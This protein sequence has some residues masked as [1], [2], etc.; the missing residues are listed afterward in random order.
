MNYPESNKQVIARAKSVLN[1]FKVQYGGEYHFGEVVDQSVAHL[2]F[3]H[4]YIV[5]KFTDMMRG[6]CACHWLAI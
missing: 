5:E 2:V 1:D 6:E 3:T 4:S